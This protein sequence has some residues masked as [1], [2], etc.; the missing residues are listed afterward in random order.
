MSNITISLKHM[1]E[2]V[3]ISIS[4]P[5]L[6][7]LIKYSTQLPAQELQEEHDALAE[8]DEE[9]DDESIVRLGQADLRR[10]ELVSVNDGDHQQYVVLEVIQLEDGS[11]HQVAVVTPDFMYEQQ[12]KLTPMFS[13]L[14][15]WNG[16]NCMIWRNVSSPPDLNW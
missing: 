11:E 15:T 1:W 14:L 8:E 16:C 6:H 2:K 3:Y 12:G 4:I 9:Q 7:V 5:Y 10:G 13:K